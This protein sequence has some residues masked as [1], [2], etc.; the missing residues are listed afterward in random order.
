MRPKIKYTSDWRM[1]RR[2][3]AIPE[4][5]ADAIV[6]AYGKAVAEKVAE[7]PHHRVHGVA[8]QIR[9][10]RASL[11]MPAPPI[12]KYKVL[13]FLNAIGLYRP[14]PAPE[15]EVNYEYANQTN[16][17]P[18]F[19]KDVHPSGIVSAAFEGAQTYAK[20]ASAAM[21]KFTNRP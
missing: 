10:L 20:A 14:R 1:M 4:H 17:D 8:E 7:A 3:S 15:N 16:I 19:F 11:L 6:L 18:G 9:E 2:D 5:I 12:W 13:E 21:N